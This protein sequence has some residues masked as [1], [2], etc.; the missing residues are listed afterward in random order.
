[1][2]LGTKYWYQLWC[3]LTSFAEE[4][5]VNEIHVLKCLKLRLANEPL[6]DKTNKMTC[7]PSQDSDPPGNP[8]SLIRVF[9]VRMKNLWALNYLLSAVKTLIS[10]GGC[11]GWSE[12][13]LGAHVSLLVLSCVSSNNDTK[14]FANSW[15]HIKLKKESKRIKNYEYH[16]IAMPETTFT[17]T[18]T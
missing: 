3:I 1:M 8:P 9:V 7:A 2:H 10:L 15:I 5:L 13:S 12:S 16:N 17:V 11:P 4:I 14:A 6:H 18:A